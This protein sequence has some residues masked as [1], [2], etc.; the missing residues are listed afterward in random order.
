MRSGT[1]TLSAITQNSIASPAARLVEES[2]NA[3]AVLDR[4][5][6]D[7]DADCRPGLPPDFPAVPRRARSVRRCA[8]VPPWRRRRGS[9]ARPTGMAQLSG[10]NR[11]NASSP[12]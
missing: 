10:L 3:P 5:R 12:A 7:R 8:G 2:L 6:R 11:G 9:G 1:D 4:G